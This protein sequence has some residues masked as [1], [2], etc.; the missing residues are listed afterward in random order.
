MAKSKTS[1]PHAVYRGGD[2]KTFRQDLSNYSELRRGLTPAMRAQT[3]TKTELKNVSPDVAIRYINALNEWRQ[4]PQREKI[5][6]GQPGEISALE[7][8]FLKGIDSG[9]YSAN[10]KA[11]LAAANLKMKSISQEQARMEIRENLNAIDRAHG[12]EWYTPTDYW[13]TKF[14]M[15]HG[16]WDPSLASDSMLRVA[17]TYG[18]LDDHP[19][20]RDETIEEYE[21]RTGGE[22]TGAAASEV[23]AYRQ[24][25]LAVAKLFIQG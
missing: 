2:V 6:R 14:Y 22:D 5:V 4:S 1:A 7:N 16:E 3:L 9:Y 20:Y 12:G 8:I 21:L 19:G 10:E 11:T 18:F 25:I 15:D 23:A 17:L 13:A 24:D